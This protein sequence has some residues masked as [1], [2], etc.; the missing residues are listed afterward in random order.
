MG[1]G[2]IRRRKDKP[3]QHGGEP[4][5]TVKTYPVVS[6][7]PQR[8]SLDLLARIEEEGE[9]LKGEE[10]VKVHGMP[11][12][13]LAEWKRVWTLEDRP[14]IGAS[15][16]VFLLYGLDLLNDEDSVQRHD[17]ATQA[18][19]LSD[20]LTL[21]ARTLLL[22]FVGSGNKPGFDFKPEMPCGNVETYTFRTSRHYK[23]ALSGRAEE[24][25][26]TQS[27][28]AIVTI[29][30]GLATQ[31][32]VDTEA[33]G[34]I[35]TTFARFSEEIDKRALEIERQLEHWRRENR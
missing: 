15:F 7:L 17:E 11:S 8:G 33:V 2:V 3:R 21:R 18:V 6:L 16:T 5:G 29:G 12:Y 13:I 24:L 35:N 30:M 14:P 10:L 22:R 20:E 9:Q 1:C 23:G 4:A 19:H 25:G 27:A 28:L 26:T 31:P 34:A 32:S